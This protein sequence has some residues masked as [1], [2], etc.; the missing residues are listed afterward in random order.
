MRILVLLAAFAFL[1]A[2]FGLIES[3]WPSVRGQRRL[4][5]G[6]LTD[7]IYFGFSPTAGKAFTAVFV[8]LVLLPPAALFQL[9][10]PVGELRDMGGR[11]SAV[12]GLPLPLQLLAFLLLADF[13]G[14]WTHRTFHTGRRLWRVH[15]VHH[16]SAELDWLSAVRVHPLNDAISTA[17]VATPLLLLGFDRLTIAAYLPFVTLYAIGLHANVT[18]DFGPL[19]YVVA[20][21]RFH[22]WHHSAAPQARDKNFAGLFA[23]WDILFGTFYLPAGRQAEDFGV[24]GEAVPESFWGQMLFPFRARVAAPEVAGAA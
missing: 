23:F 22:R 21:P 20:S 10:M 1:S 2:L 12:T 13:I 24:S 16:S 11:E 6:F 18:W 17:L 19:R 4:R 3:R 5:R 14:Y 9:P 15:A 8:F 7:L